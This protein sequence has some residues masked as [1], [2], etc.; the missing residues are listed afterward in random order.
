MQ[1][2]NPA[3]AYEVSASLVVSILIFISFVFTFVSIVAFQ[4]NPA[5]NSGGS[6]YKL[7]ALF[8]AYLLLGINTVSLFSLGSGTESLVL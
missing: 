1:D 6:L 4:V 2:L 8:F 3:A 7:V 5:T